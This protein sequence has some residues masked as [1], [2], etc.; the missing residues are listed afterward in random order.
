[1]SYSIIQLLKNGKLT[2]K[3]YA[4]WKSNLNKVLVNNALHFVL[5]KECLPSPAQNASQNVRDVDNHWTKA[6]TR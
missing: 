1:M 5:M 4:T 6:I 3:N 2:G